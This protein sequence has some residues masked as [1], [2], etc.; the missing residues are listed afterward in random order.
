MKLKTLFVSILAATCLG[1]SACNPKDAPKSSEE[2]VASSSIEEPSSDEPIES[3][4]NPVTSS[5][6]PPHEHAFGEWTQVSAPTCTEKGKEERVCAC[7]EKEERDIDALGH[8]PGEWEVVLEPTV[9]AEGQKVKKCT[10]CQEVLE[11][12]VIDKLTPPEPTVDPITLTAADL[13]GYSGTNIAYKDGEGTIGGIK[14][15]YI[16][17]GAYGNGI[18]MRTKNGKSSTI[19]NVDV[20][21]GAVKTV[22]INLNKDKTVYDNEHA[23]TFSFGSTAECADK[24]ITW[25]TV[26][27]TLAYKFNVGAEGCVYFKLVHSITYSLYVDSIEL[28]F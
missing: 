26:K 2:P 18:Q 15:N 28:I 13:M 27:D 10:R 22:K 23:L 25:D 20:L 4:E 16:G 12:E 17:C 6:E 24:S 11:I 5:E 8:N 9:D 7:G 19:Y 3:S 1:I 14:F 21:P